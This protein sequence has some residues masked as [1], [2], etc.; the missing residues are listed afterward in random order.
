M[1]RDGIDT[2]VDLDA[3][4]EVGRMAEEI[5]GHQNRLTPAVLTHSAVRPWPEERRRSL[6]TALSAGSAVGR[7]S[8]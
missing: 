8:R 5:V 6:V 1:R 4:I 3:L 7:T 2:G